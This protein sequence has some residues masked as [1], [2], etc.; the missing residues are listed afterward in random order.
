MLNAR[1][2]NPLYFWGNVRFEKTF[3]KD[4]AAFLSYCGLGGVSAG[5]ES[6]TGTG[7]ESIN[8]GTDI[9]SITRACC[10]SA[11]A[12]GLPEARL[13]LSNAVIILAT[14]P[15]SNSA[16]TSSK[17][18]M[19]DVEAGLGMIP[20]EPLRS[21]LYKG[22]KYPHDYP[23]HYVRQQYLPD[24][25]KDRVYYKYGENRTEQAAAAYAS[26]IGSLKKGANSKNDT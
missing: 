26:S 22:Y 20:P 1:A 7:L 14:A 12:L 15:K 18:A 2:G 11:E 24:D 5:I 25:L 3:T 10:E 4:L 16:E 8:K 19:A 21:P 9:A 17:A 6:A 13:P 23:G